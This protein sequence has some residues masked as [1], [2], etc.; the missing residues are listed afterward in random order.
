MTGTSTK[1]T[2]AVESYFA[3]LGRVRASGGATGERSSYGPLANLLNTVGATLKPKVFCVGELADHGVGHPDFG[4]YAAKQ[5]QRGRPREGQIPERGVVEVKSSHED[6]QAWA[7]R[8]QVGRY[9]TR[10]R[11]VLMT[12]LREFVLLG[13]DSA[14]HEATLETFQLAGSDEE[15]DRRLQTPRTFAREVGTGLGEYLCRA[16]SHRAALTRTERLGVAARLLCPRWSR[17]G[18]G[19]G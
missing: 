14:G 5:V 1:P 8:E 10:Y 13:E 19:S 6:M 7:V 17:A 9:W 18:R 16:L 15:F 11:L 4:L 3:D 12:N 2:A